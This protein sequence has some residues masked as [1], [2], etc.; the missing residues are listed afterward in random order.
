MVISGIIE[1][2]QLLLA[3][4][5]LQSY[6][7]DTT[8]NQ[9]GTLAI[10]LVG[11]D[12]ASHLYVSIKQEQA[13]KY[14]IS[15]I[16]KHFDQLI[17][18]AELLNEISTL[19]YD[20]A[21]TGIIVQLPLPPTIETEAILDSITPM[22]DVDNLTNTGTFT[23]PMVLSVEALIKQYSIDLKGK[24]ICVLGQGRL[25]GKPVRIWLESLGF[26]PVV[27]DEETEDSDF[28]LREA[29]V[30]FAGSGQKHIINELIVHKDQIIF[31]CSGRDVD[32]ETVKDKVTAL[33]PSKGGVGPLT[34]HFLFTNCLKAS[35]TKSH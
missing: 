7:P 30:I 34:V 2:M 14:G 6:S 3:E 18:Q 5:I 23:S 29:Y 21:I 13:K 26:N 16:I 19:N 12:R 17:T 9:N 25:I 11:E 28:I 10:I 1:K 35:Q 31:D 4:P 27:V 22:K 32:F 20:H 33:T 15:V 8:I 24:N